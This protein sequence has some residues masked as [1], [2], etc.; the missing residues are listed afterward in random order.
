MMR[1][2][3]MGHAGFAHL[4]SVNCALFASFARAR[5]AAARLLFE[6]MILGYLAPTRSYAPETVVINRGWCESDERYGV[7]GDSSIAA[8]S[9]I[10]DMFPYST[11]LP[12][13]ISVIH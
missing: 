3:G 4:W 10:V 5:A 9:G 8:G 12:D 6:G 11:S 7:I 2:L 13:G 1:S